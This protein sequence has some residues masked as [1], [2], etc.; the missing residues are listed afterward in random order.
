LLIN[1]L[2]ELAFEK[3]QS[4]HRFCIVQRRS[5]VLTASELLESAWL[6]LVCGMMSVITETPTKAKHLAG[7]SSKRNAKATKF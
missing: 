3:M 5:E 6:F 2:D 1:L 4:Y 7:L